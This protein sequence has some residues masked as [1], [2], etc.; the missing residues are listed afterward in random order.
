MHAE[1]KPTDGF[2]KLVTHIKIGVMYAEYV[3]HPIPDQEMVYTFIMVIMKCGLFNTSYEKW[4][5]RPDKNKTWAKA[6]V[7]WNEE[8]NLK[9]TCAVTAGKYGFVGNATAAS[10]TDADAAYEQSV[11]DFSLAFNKSQTTISGLTATNTQL[12]QQL[13]QAKMMCQ[14]MTNFAPPPT[15]QMPFQ[16]QQKMQIQQQ[17]WK[18]N[19]G[20]GQVNGRGNYKGKKRNNCNGGNGGNNGNNWNPGNGNNTSGG[21][22]K[23]RPW[24]RHL[25]TRQSIDPKNIKYFNRDYYCWK[26]VRNISNE[27]ISHT[28]SQQHP[29][30]MHNFNA[31]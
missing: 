18:N 8:V 10:T 6:T 24:R 1:W 25:T 17:N 30:G 29:S 7:F 14:A 26:H 21:G 22:Q 9:R 20:G 2:E 19:G 23:Q 11:N 27:H 16:P 13:Q 15:Y 12:Q 28:C 4:H 5:A 31:T 3:N